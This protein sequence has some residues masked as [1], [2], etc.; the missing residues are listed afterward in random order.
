[1]SRP[2]PSV[3][4]KKQYPHVLPELDGGTDDDE[5]GTSQ[6]GFPYGPRRHLTAAASHLQCVCMVPPMDGVGG[7]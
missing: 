5:F 2:T 7:L 1:M 4:Q 3:L 6:S